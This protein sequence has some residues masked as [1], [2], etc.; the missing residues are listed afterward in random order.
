MPEVVCNPTPL[1]YLHQ[2]GVLQILPAGREAGL[3]S[4]GWRNFEFLDNAKPSEFPA[5]KTPRC[6][7]E[8]AAHRVLGQQG[9]AHVERLR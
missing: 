6:Q 4:S 3:D 7:L 9:S 5:G 1:Q 2:T 8:L